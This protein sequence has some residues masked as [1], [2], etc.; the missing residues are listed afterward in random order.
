MT[1]GIVLAGGTG[2]RLWPVTHAVSKQLLPVYDKPMVYYPIA[3]LMSAGIRR[4]LLITRPDEQALFVKLLRDGSH[5]GLDISYAAQPEP[6]GIAAAFLIAEEWLEGDDPAVLILGDNLFHGEIVAESVRVRDEFCG[7]R[8]FA[9][10]VADARAYGVVEVSPTGRALSIEEKPE[11]PKSNYAIPG[12]YVYDSQV[13]PLVRRLTPSRRGELEISD[14]NRLYMA[15]GD[16]EVVMLPRGVAWLDTGTF[17]DLHDASAYIKTIEARQ[18]IRV[19]ALEEIAWRQGWISD[20]D[21]TALAGKYSTTGYGQ[22]LQ[23]L[24]YG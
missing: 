1:Q 21:L 13:L 24:V 10:E 6:N 14:L 15:A 7:A 23:G 4:I 12:L 22:Y 5:L 18:G 8:I 3:T 20:S 19:A 9:Y 16:L 17:S 11:R 2:S